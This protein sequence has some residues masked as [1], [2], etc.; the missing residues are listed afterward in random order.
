[1]PCRYLLFAQPNSYIFTLKQEGERW[2]REF[3]SISDAVTYAGSLPGSE[4]ATVSVFDAAG[5]QLAELRV[6]ENA[7]SLA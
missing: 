2:L 5:I 1:M 6:R 4:D 7:F 3:P